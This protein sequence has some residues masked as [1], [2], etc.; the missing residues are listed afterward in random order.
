MSEPSTSP[1][2][3][4]DVKTPLASEPTTTS[5]PEAV[6][7]EPAPT[8]HTPVS[9]PEATMQPTADEPAKSGKALYI[10]IAV[11]LFVVAFGYIALFTDT[12]SNLTPRSSGAVVA[13]VN[14]TSITRSELTNSVNSL[15]ET[16]RLQG[17]DTEDPTVQSQ[18]QEEALTRLINTKL[19]LAA[20]S[21]QGISIDDATIDAELANLEASFGGAE[22]LAARL[23]ELNISQADL[24]R[25]VSEQLLV[26]EYLENTSAVAEIEV[27][28]E[29]VATF[30]ENAKAQFGDE[31]PPLEEVRADI[32][33]NITNQKQQ[34]VLIEIVS[35][36]RAEADV[37][38]L[39]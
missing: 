39:I 35:G 15:V 26:A 29:E 16:L 33:Q 7:V 20:A 21:N 27:T 37:E 9:T 4:T 3:E 24:R 38:V 8:E 32:E 17:V 36:L 13:T 18:I 10:G 6:S 23:D 22:G 28:E 25:D 11:A 2:P 34:S 12:G 19:L 1:K 30:Y 31:L 5:Q 14:D